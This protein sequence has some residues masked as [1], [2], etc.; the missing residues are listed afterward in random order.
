MTGESLPHKNP[1]DRRLILDLLKDVATGV[2]C[3]FAADCRRWLRFVG[4]I[5]I[6]NL[7][8]LLFDNL[9]DFLLVK[10]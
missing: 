5:I 8:L 6:V 9:N 10:K 1:D 3:R 4:G 7:L 2:D